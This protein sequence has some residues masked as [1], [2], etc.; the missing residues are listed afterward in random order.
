[1]PIIIALH[2]HRKNPS[3]LLPL[4]AFNL[5]KRRTKILTLPCTTQNIF[6]NGSA[7]LSEM[8]ERKLKKKK[9]NNLGLYSLY[10]KLVNTK[11]RD[12]ETQEFT[13]SIFSV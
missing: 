3:S 1:M 11:D 12:F 10:N 7:L 8:K 13:I 9:P 5:P 2:R 6:L 4:P